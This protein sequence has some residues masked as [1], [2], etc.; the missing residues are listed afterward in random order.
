MIRL[1]YQVTFKFT[2]SKSQNKG[3]KM[4]KEWYDKGGPKIDQK[5]MT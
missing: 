3:S 4:L 5:V 2:D 1:S